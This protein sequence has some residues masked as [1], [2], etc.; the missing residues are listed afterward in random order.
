MKR[1][2]LPRVPDVLGLLEVQTS[3]TV[4]GIEAFATWSASG[5]ANAARAVRDA[6]HRADDARR[7]LSAQL[8]IA[9]TTPLDPEDIYE[10]SERLDAVLNG[11]KNA[12]REAELMDMRPNS[13]LADM[14]TLVA[15]GVQHIATAFDALPD[16]KDTATTEAD[17]AIHCERR[18][19]RCY[20]RA[21]SDL[22]SVEDVGAVTAWRELYRRYARIGEGLVFVAERIWYAVVKTS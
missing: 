15:K 7:E 9:F 19:E 20:R 16:D 14:A 6:E 10:M 12:V 5:D 17:A 22:L 13:A 3:V 8:R 11:A 2:F 18:I 4:E 21:M 1:W